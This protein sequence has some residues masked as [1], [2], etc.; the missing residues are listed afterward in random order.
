MLKIVRLKRCSKCKM[1]K[2]LTEFN[3]HKN[4]KDGLR[5]ECKD[6]RNG[7]CRQ[8]VKN[9][10]EKIKQINRRYRINHVNKLKQ[11]RL[12]N[13]LRLN[14]NNIKFRLNNTDYYKVYSIKWRKDNPEQAKIINRKAN[15]QRRSTV[16]GRLNSNMG[17][18]IWQALKGN[19]AGKHWED[20]VG[21]TIG[22]LKNQLESKF[23]P[24]MTWENYGK[25]HIDHIIPKAFFI[26]ESINDV[27]FQYCWSLDNLQPLWAEDNWSKQTKLISL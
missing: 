20:I 23:L 18:A 27:E 19:K 6:C 8:R 15:K 12:N 3:I 4:H 17:T 24:G 25:W 22:E 13:K 9:N 1:E 7:Y 10:P 21:Y 5:S 2:E 14:N 11:Y 26:F 16:I